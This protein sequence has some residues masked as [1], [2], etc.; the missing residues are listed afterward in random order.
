MTLFFGLVY[1]GSSFGAFF[2]SS[3]YVALTLTTY[4][5][6]RHHLPPHNI[7]HPSPPP[8]PPRSGGIDHCFALLEMSRSVHEEEARDCRAKVTAV[9]DH[10]AANGF[11]TRGVLR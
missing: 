2:I 10:Y 8:P 3:L 4:R 9:M 5:Q 1:S 11:I 7:S 6:Q